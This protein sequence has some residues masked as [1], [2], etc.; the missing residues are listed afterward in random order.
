MNRL[1]LCAGPLCFCLL[2]ATLTLAGQPEAY[3]TGDR[4]A[5]REANPLGR[6]LLYVDPLAFLAGVGLS[7]GLYAAALALAPPSAARVLA[8]V[9]LFAHAL[10]ASTWLVR[11]G[12]AGYLLAALVLLAAS[13][14]LGHGWQRE[15]GS[16]EPSPASFFRLHAIGIVN[17]R[18][19]PKRKRGKE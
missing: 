7:L 15:P 2:D 11:W 13:R 5:A 19:S 17:R 18:G 1:R 4:L 10:G 6:W 14:V 8:F 9:I 3:W 16:A 12:L